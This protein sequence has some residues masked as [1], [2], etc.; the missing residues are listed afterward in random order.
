VAKYYTEVLNQ[1]TT[2]RATLASAIAMVKADSD[3]STEAAIV[4][5]IGQGLL[6]G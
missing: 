5:L 3:V 2:D 1:S 6:G 4:T